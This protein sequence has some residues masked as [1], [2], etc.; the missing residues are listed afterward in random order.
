MVEKMVNL[1]ESSSSVN[2]MWLKWRE[3]LGVTG[4]RPPPG[5]PIAPT[6]MISTNF[7]K[8]PTDGEWNKLIP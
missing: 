2:E 3:N 8:A 1:E 6:N 7:L 5:G 4:F